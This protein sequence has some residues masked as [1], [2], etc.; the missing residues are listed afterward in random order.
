[1]IYSDRQ[2]QV[3]RTELF[4]LQSAL[5]ATLANKAGEQE[6]LQAIQIDALRSQIADIEAEMA[7]YDLLRIGKV[8]FS[9]TCALSELPRVLVQARIAKG[10]SQTDL[11]E[12]LNM[13]PQQVQRYE[14]TNYMS[15]S[16]AR[17][18]EVAK[19]LDVK[20]SESFEAVGT[21]TPASA[22]FAWHDADD[23]SWSRLPFREM[24]RRKW[25][26]VLPGQ[27]A[28]E[29]TRQ[30]FITMAG[31]QFATAMHRKKVRSGN[32]PNEYALLAWQARILGL[33]KKISEKQR[34]KSFEL[35]D[36]WLRELVRLTNHRKGPQQARKLLLD[37][38]ILLVIERHLPGTYLDGAAMLSAN[39]QPVIGLTLRYDRLDNFWFVLFHELGHIFLHLFDNLKFDFFDE[40]DGSKMDHIEQQADDFALNT[41]IPPNVWDRCLSRFAMTE[42]AV[43]IDAQNLGIHVSIIAGRIRKERNNYTIFNNLIGQDL[44]REQLEDNNGP[45][46]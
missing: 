6:W 43:R 31:P 3:S 10:L 14:A 9:E 19:V 46:D 25:L 39:G 27:S 26:N 12:R 21:N 23:V 13:K 36:A 33:V 2:Y 16:L 4:K 42:E 34:I 15:A 44:V 45:E 30:F 17:L 28:I 11:A 7:E 41:L 20:I 1:M 29:A 8:S 5:E 35:N 37:R 38:G 18:I 22:I 40:E 32:V 24:I